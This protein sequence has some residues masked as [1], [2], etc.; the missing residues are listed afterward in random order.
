MHHQ[1]MSKIEAMKIDTQ[2]IELNVLKG[3]SEY[4]DTIKLLQIELSPAEC[5]EGAPDLLSV[6]SFITNELGFERLSPEPRYHDEIN[7]VAQQYEGLY[8]KRTETSYTEL[9]KSKLELGAIATSIGGIPK[10]VANSIDYGPNWFGSCLTSWRKCAPEVISISEMRPPE[11][12]IKWLK[13]ESKP[14]ISEVLQK[15]NSATKKSVLLTNADILFTDAIREAF[16]S[17]DPEV[18][19]YGRRFDVEIDPENP[20]DL[21]GKGYYSWGFDFFILPSSLLELVNDGASFPHFLR[22]GEPWWDY[23]LP[24]F[25]LSKGYPTKRLVT[26]KEPAALHLRH[27]IVSNKWLRQHGIDFIDWLKTIKSEAPCPI[28]GLLEEWLSPGIC[29]EING[30]HPKLARK[31]LFQMP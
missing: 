18:F 24:V 6:D 25:A 29:E 11:G 19:Y 20:E 4:K 21:V 9:P 23:A 10:R 15:L 13:T 31:I 5:Y 2:G 3:L 14:T 1:L 27:P 28:S 26:V 12:D 16:Q 8:L 30:H 22:I 17:L 7:E